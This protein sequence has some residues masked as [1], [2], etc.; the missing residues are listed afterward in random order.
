MA[1]IKKLI[2]G[3]K[4]IILLVV[5]GIFLII[6]ILLF[7]FEPK[8]E[9]KRV[10]FD[11]KGGGIIFNHQ[12]HVELKDLICEE[13]HHNFEDIGINPSAN[14]RGCHYGQAV[15]K[16]CTNEPIHKKCI[17][18]NCIGCHLDGSVDC[19]FCHNAENFV[20]PPPPGKILFESD[21]GQVNFDHLIHASADGYDLACNT[22]HHGYKPENKKSFPMNCRRCHYNKKYKTVCGKEE[23]HIRCVGKKCVDCHTDGAEDCEICHKE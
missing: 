16:S 17:A 13:C 10:A 4:K 22:C 8:E 3:T 5:V 11:T 15:N 12:A 1:K 23:T 20:T 6:A 9:P 14:C 19:N 18:K 21:G 2:E 7:G